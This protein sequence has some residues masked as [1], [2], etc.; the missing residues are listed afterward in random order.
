MNG[1]WSAPQAKSHINVLE[2]QTVLLAHGCHRA[3]VLKVNTVTLVRLKFTV[4]VLLVVH[5]MSNTQF[6]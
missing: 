6:V 4:A 2:L 3:Y 5:Q 1:R